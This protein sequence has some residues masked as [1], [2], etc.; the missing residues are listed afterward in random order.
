MSTMLQD[1]PARLPFLEAISWYDRAPHRL[2]PRQMLTRYEAGWRFVG[3]LAEPS[4][5]ERDWICYLVERHG[6]TIDPYA[7]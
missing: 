2:S 5:E 4:R 1:V 7:G 3:V 6:S